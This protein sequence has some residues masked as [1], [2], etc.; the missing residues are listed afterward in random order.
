MYKIAI[1]GPESS[2]KTELCRCLA[3]HFQEPWVEE[4]AREYLIKQKGKYKQADLW[5]IAKGQLL[6]E[7]ETSSKANNFLFC[8]TTLLVIKV[9]TQYK[10]GSIQTE[11]SAHYTA[12][13]YDL[14][15]LLRPDIEYKDDPLRENPSIEDRNEL[16]EIYRQHLIQDKA[17]Y[18]VVGGK[19]NE[20]LKNALKILHSHFSF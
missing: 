14:H 9:W 1:V 6:L 17:N 11:V 19:G 20:R 15:L 2:G 4:F 13:D 8:D 18:A 7:E 3:E 5:E 16:F 12:A 10:Y